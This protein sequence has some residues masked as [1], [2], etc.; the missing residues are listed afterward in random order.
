[1]KSIL[2]LFAH[3]R[4]EQSRANKFLVE[5]YKEFDQVTFRDLYELYPDFNID[6][7]AEQALIASSDVVVFHHPFYWYS[8]PPLLKQ[9]IDLV[10]EFGW[11]YGPGGDA[12]KGK[13]VLNCITSGGGEEVYSREGRN[14]YTVKEFLRPFERTVALCKMH[15][16][17]PFLTQGTHR[18][19]NEEFVKQVVLYQQLLRF[20]LEASEADLEYIQSLDRLNSLDPAKSKSP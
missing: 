15:Y 8:A 9:W 16:L 6:I 13:W 1:M 10:L 11:A 2:V 7:S 20:L 4:F 17:P 12:L 5:A 3:P 14:K 19:S 18:L